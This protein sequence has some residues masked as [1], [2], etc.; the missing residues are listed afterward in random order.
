MPYRLVVDG[1]VLDHLLHSR[2][3]AVGR[4]MET[5]S[6]IFQ[7][8][9]IQDCPK[10]TNKLSESIVRRWHEGVGELTVTVVAAQ[11]YAIYVHNGTKPHVI[12]GN[13]TLAFNW[14]NGP[15]GPGLYFFKSVQHPGTKPVPF[16]A[17]N[18]PLIFAA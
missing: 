2:D 6:R 10:R 9:A 1:A 16:L 8:A 18:I 13:P 3:G 14:D 4:Y 11:P 15:N 7:M 5:R 17:R 12:Q